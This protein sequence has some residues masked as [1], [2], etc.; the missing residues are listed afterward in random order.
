M[1][2]PPE[3]GRACDGHALV[4]VPHVMATETTGIDVGTL[5]RVTVFPGSAQQWTIED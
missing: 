1:I 2:C 5:A 4:A 3:T